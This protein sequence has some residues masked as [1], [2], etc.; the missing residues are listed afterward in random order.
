MVMQ[1]PT[2]SITRDLLEAE[3]TEWVKPEIIAEVIFDQ[4]KE[5]GIPETL[6]NAKTLYM[7]FLGDQ[8][9]EGIKS[10]AKHCPAFKE[11]WSGFEPQPTP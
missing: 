3:F 10:C 4:L 11:F 7:D 9:Y 1:Q 6:E 8:I 5:D 2:E